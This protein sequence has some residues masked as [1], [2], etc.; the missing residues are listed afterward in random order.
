MEIFKCGDRMVDICGTMIPAC[1]IQIEGDLECLTPF[2]WT[3]FEI[4]W[5]DGTVW[6]VFDGNDN[7]EIVL[8]M[9]LPGWDSKDK[10]G[11]KADSTWICDNWNELVHLYNA[12]VQ[13]IGNAKCK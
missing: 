11:V 4:L 3:Y 5:E 12:N 8:E 2:E 1:N 9:W 10:W 6:E 7:R 13:R